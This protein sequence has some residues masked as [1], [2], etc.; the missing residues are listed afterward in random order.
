MASTI[1]KAF[2]RKLGQGSGIARNV[3]KDIVRGVRLALFEGPVVGALF[4]AKYYV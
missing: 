1:Y 2:R 4:I 3:I